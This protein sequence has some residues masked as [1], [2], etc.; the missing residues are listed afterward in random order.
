MTDEKLI[1]VL[2]RVAALHEASVSFGGQQ[3]LDSADEALK[4]PLRALYEDPLDPAQRQRLLALVGV[5]TSEQQGFALDVA[6][7]LMMLR[8]RV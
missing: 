6:V 7:G 5:H 8:L 1:D 2:R 4:V 3:A